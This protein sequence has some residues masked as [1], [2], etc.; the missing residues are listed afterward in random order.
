[1]N[2]QNNRI[3]AITFATSLIGYLK[4]DAETP[5]ADLFVRPNSPESP[6]TDLAIVA[7][8]CRNCRPRLR[9]I[10]QFI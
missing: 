7:E 9:I 5:M 8:R 2:R 3:V 4:L 10:Q 1:M 6:S